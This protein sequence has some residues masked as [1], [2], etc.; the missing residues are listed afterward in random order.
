[1][2]IAVLIGGSG[3]DS[4]K[5]LINGILDSALLDGTEVYIFTCDAWSHGAC[6]KHEKGEYN[7]YNLPDFTQYDGVIV[8]LNTIHDPETV[9]TLAQRLSKSGVPC[10]SLNAKFDGAVCITMENQLGTRAIAEHLIQVHGVRRIYY[11]SGPADNQ[12]AQERLE[13]YRN[14]M[15]EYHLGWKEENIYYGDYT[16]QSGVKAAEYFLQSDIPLPDVIMAANDRM[17]IG[18]V[19]KL[20]SAGYIVPEDII[21]T[22]YDDS[23]MGSLNYPRI[24]TVRKG[25]YAAGEM[26]YRKLKKIWQKDGSVE[27]GIIYGKP[28]FSESCGCE[29]RNYYTHAELQELYVDKQLEV[30]FNQTLL[31]DSAAEFAGLEHFQDLM[32]S[33]KK[34]IKQINPEY[35]YLCTNSDMESCFVETDWN[36]PATEPRRDTSAFPDDIC[37]PFA[38]ERGEFRKYECFD[39]SLLLPPDCEK[40]TGANFYVVLPLHHQDNCFGYCVIGNYKQVID[41]SLFQHFMMNLCIAMELVRKQ[42]AVRELLQKLNDG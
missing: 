12:A 35:F 30:D 3:Y 9:D 1:M 21:V 27:D 20:L 42:G 4:Q 7:I 17:A 31:K 6:H 18:A 25:M 22:G 11:I 13:V 40:G 32:D 5:R 26:A 8:S 16:Y 36:H 33:L 38:Y 34:Y 15:D 19:R 29:R 23:D 39:K 24:T 28:I 41:G 2:K 14:V 37:V 10:I